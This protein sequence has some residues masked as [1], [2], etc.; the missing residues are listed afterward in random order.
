MLVTIYIDVDRTSVKCQAEI[1]GTPILY[2]AGKFD[3]DCRLYISSFHKDL[4]LNRRMYPLLGANIFCVLVQY[5]F[6]LNY[7]D[8]NDNICLEIGI[9]AD[10]GIVNYYTQTLGMMPV[11]H[12]FAYNFVTLSVENFIDNCNNSILNQY[13]YDVVVGV[14]DSSS[15]EESSFSYN[16]NNIFMF[17]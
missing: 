16:D 14:K 7:L 15:D 2:I 3:T 1:D 13:D 4:A 9:R 11:P 6:E 10:A 8:L 17:E 5:L 12:D